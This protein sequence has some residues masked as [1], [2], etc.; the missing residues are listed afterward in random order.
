MKRQMK[1]GMFYWQC[2]HHIAAWRHPDSVPNSGVNLSHLI[3]LAKLSEKGLF[4]MF[5]MADSVTFWRGDLDAMSRDSF[6]TWI[7]PFTLMATIAQHTKNLGVVCTATSTYDQPYL[8][9]RRFASLDI[10]SGGR[11]GWNLVTSGNKIEADSFGLEKHLEKSVRYRRAAEFAHVVRG[12]WNSWN[13]DT[14]IHDKTSG[15]YFD[16]NKLNILDHKGEFF[17]VRGPLNVPN[18]PQGEPVLIQ[19]GAS[20]DGRQLAAETAE[21]VFGAS[22]TLEK[23]QEFYSDV[24]KRMVACERDPDGLKIMPGL[25]VSVGET[26]E[27]AVQK[28]EDL[29]DLIDPAT[30][31]ELLSQRMDYDFSGLDI[32]EPVPEIAPNEIG[33]SRAELMLDMARREK[34]TIKDLYRRIAGARGHCHISGTPAEIAD[35]MEEWLNHDGCDGFNIMPPLFPSGLEDFINMVIPELQRRGIYRTRYEGSTLRQNLGLSRPPYAVN[36]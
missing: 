13:D 9:A 23:A 1:L 16:K 26:H 11:A 30:G 2:G 15:L 18:S 22:Q 24:K 7:E 5:F 10:T 6:G 34:L 14:F 17:T 8:L 28:Y 29:Q 35:M 3:E 21:V 20:E 12:L 27:K 31:L 33:G 4:D 32:N 25:S 36:I 19:A